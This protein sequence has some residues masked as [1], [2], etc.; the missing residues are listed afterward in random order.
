MK[1]ISDPVHWDNTLKSTAI[2]NCDNT[3]HFRSLKLS[4]TAY[5]EGSN[6]PLLFFH[7]TGFTANSYAPL[8]QLLHEAGHPVFALNF[9]GH[10]GSDSTHDFKDWTFF[11]DQVEAFAHHLNLKKAIAVGHSIGGASVLHASARKLIPFQKIVLLDPTVFSPFSSWWVPFFPNPLARAAETRRST[12]QNLKVVERSFRM[13][14]LFK[15]WHPDSFRGY[16]QSAF[17]PTPEGFRLQLEPDLEARIFRSFH[18]GQWS[19]F[20][21]SQL[22][23]LLITAR[24]SGVTPPSAVKLLLARSSRGMWIEHPGSHCFPMEDPAGVAHHVISFINA[25]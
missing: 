23:L 6:I 20:K 24:K 2:E 21:M 25:V 11:G 3:F 14:P 18:R 15:N 4:Y 12:F 22:P 8:H 1:H 7:A 5:A 19:V 10:G 9:M 16:L 13:H 17:A